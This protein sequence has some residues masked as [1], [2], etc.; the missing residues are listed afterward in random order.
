[1]ALLFENS[2]T[3]FPVVTNIFG[4]D[5]RIAKALGVEGV[6]EFTTKI[7]TLL[8]SALSPKHT[9][10]DKLKV[11][12]LLGEVAGWMPKRVKGRG[13]CQH[14][15]I[16]GDAVDLSQLPI[17]K[18][19]PHDGAPFITL[20]LVH[21]IDPHTGGRNVGMY[22]MQV[23]SRNTTGMHWHTHKT[24]ERHY[25]AYK[26]L[27]QK[28]P[29]SV[30]LGGDPAY[31]YSATAPLPD[32]IDE[33]I[34][35]G[36]IRGKGAEMVKCITNNHY[37]PADA[38][39]VIEGYI[40]PAEDKVIEGPFADHTGFY[41]L[42][43]YFPLFHVTCITHKKDAI[44]P[45]TLVGIP[46]KEDAYIAKATEKIFLSPIKAVMQP[47]VRDMWLPEEGVAH[48]LALID[49][50]KRYNGQGVKVGLS[51]LGAGQ[52]M[53][54]KAVVI[55]CDNSEK[56]SH[57]ST[58]K[59]IISRID[60]ERDITI[61]SGVMDILDHTSPEVGVGGKMVI[62]AT[63]SPTT[64]ELQL[65]NE[66]IFTDDVL[67]IN[68]KL[69]KEGYS[70]IFVN[71]EH[72]TAN[73]REAL[74]HFVQKN[75]IKGVKF[76]IALDSNVPLDNNATLIW[77]ASG[78]SDMK[79]DTYISNGTL[80]IDGRAKF[81]EING[82]KRPWPN[83]IAMNNE[84]IELVDKKWEEY[85]IGEFIASP[86]HRYKQLLFKGEAFVK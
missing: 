18:C 26:E 37:V 81:D 50:D 75:G 11:I 14:T 32:G 31:T 33:Y 62:D 82:F 61:T 41:S 17:L 83:V 42:E 34:L 80:Y 48:N 76:V 23:M 69:A 78:N 63:N 64:E 9:L 13:A 35:S 84:T 29:I 49:I 39:I 58:I 86:T 57:P 79:R 2:G 68:D 10:M 73:F 16:K 36:F 52:M 20:P 65:P 7:D 44:Y 30:V 74:T 70:T 53:F 85:N 72:K 28:M 24:G 56:L 38:D 77:L 54:C 22:R 6:E 66:Y 21:T 46:P 8:G 27:G 12:P 19:A 3:K 51:L 5:K 15:I 71:M 25:R 60:I 55:S 47:E 67:S 59:G 1:M 45:A 40:D 4:S 43:D